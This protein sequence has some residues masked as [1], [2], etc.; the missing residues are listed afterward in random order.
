MTCKCVRVCVPAVA[1]GGFLIEDETRALAGCP[2]HR[3]EQLL[4][5]W[6]EGRAVVAAQDLEGIL[7]ACRAGEWCLRDVSLPAAGVLGEFWRIVRQVAH[8][9]VAA[10]AGERLA[11][12]A[13]SPDDPSSDL[14]GRAS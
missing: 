14:S 1:R 2:M 4:V 11:P 13:C 7:E 6:H 12:S 9:Q 8:G 10:R 3:L 5:R